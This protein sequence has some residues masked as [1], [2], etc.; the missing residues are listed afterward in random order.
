MCTYRKQKPGTTDKMRKRET[1]ASHSK[2]SNYFIFMCNINALISS[3]KN[4]NTE[5]QPKQQIKQLI[6]WRFPEDILIYWKIQLVFWEDS[7]IF[8]WI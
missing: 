7:S 2:H 1:I 8:D 4:R 5:N 6:F 3:G